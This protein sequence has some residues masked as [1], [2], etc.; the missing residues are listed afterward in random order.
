MRAYELIKE[1]LLRRSY[2]PVIHIVWLAIYVL[3]FQLPVSDDILWGKVPF[4]LCGFMLP[5]ILSNG[6][7]GNDISSGRI[8]VLITKPMRIGELYIWRFIGLSIQGAIHLCVCGFIIFF[9]HNIQGKGSI[10]N[11]ILWLL[12]SWLLFN[13]WSA[14]STTVSV[15]I[16]RGNNFMVLFFC[17]VLVFALRSILSMSPTPIYRIVMTIIKYA[18]P[19]VELLFACGAGEWSLPQK[20][21]LLAYVIGLTTI[22]I[23]I[24]VVILS[25]RDFKRQYD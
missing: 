2:I 8:T 25:N 17:I 12:L 10:E 13:A 20:I 11:L 6:I 23:G 7:F 5:L 21:G 14:L 9:L 3:L 16:K 19:P 1:T 24:G 18:F 15:F 4:V 22:Y